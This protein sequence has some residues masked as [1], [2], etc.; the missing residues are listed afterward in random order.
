MTNQYITSSNSSVN[1]SLTNNAADFPLGEKFYLDVSHDDIIISVLTAMSLDYLK[2]AP[3]L[4]QYPPN[5]NRT[6]VLSHLTPFGARLITEVIGCNSATPVTKP[7]HS[8][9]YYLGQN[10]YEA[11]TA[12]NKFIRLRLNHG[13]LPLSSIRGG[14][15]VGRTDG[16]C[17]LDN[18][19]ESQADADALANYQF[20][21][22][23]NYTIT[24]PT[25]GQDYDGTIM[26]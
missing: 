19:L 6:F 3:D 8:A 14:Q 7:A 4:T 15:C 18:F 10:G 11:S 20:S 1:S 13:I 22:F 23:G 12:T 21:C 26:A 16:L 9:Q 2:D 25:N 5:P 24:N 17:A